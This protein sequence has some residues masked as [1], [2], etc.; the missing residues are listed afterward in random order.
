MK[1]ALALSALCVLAA[2]PVR[3]LP[4]AIDLDRL[5]GAL[6]AEGFAVPQGE[7]V[8][9]PPPAPAGALV[10]TDPADGPRVSLV[11]LLDRHWTATDLFDDAAG[12]TF[13][14]GTLDLA[15]DGW[16]VV[17]PPG[18][19]AQMVKI[20]RG[21][22]GSWSAGG[23]RY[24]V[25]LDVSIFRARLANII[26]IKDGSG[27][28][29]WKRRIIDLFQKTY[30]AGRAIVVDGRPYRL[31]LSRMPGSGRPAAPTTQVGL[32]LIYD[33]RDSSGNHAQYDFYRFP[34]SSLQGVSLAIK[35]F[36]GDPARLEASSDGAELT[37]SR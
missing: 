34:F 30:D 32:C 22:S 20:E 31:F 6:G 37:I 7:L 12:R 36:N 16:L 27:A 33:E 9:P 24:S 29:V 1:I 4:G 35:L 8:S 2:A 13:V 23:R 25:D 28:T 14:S 26:E 10:E 18:G 19:S 21:M 17:T 3:A 11:G 5:G 15:G